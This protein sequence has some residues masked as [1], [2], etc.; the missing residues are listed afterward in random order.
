MKK[1]KKYFYNIITIMICLII[2][3]LPVS[4][5]TEEENIIDIK[6]IDS[7][8]S[9]KQSFGKVTPIMDTENDTSVVKKTSQ[10]TPLLA[11]GCYDGTPSGMCSSTKPRYCDESNTL[12]N[13]CSICGCSDNVRYRCES[14]GNCYYGNFKAELY[15]DYDEDREE[16]SLVYIDSRG[17]G[18]Y[19]YYGCSNCSWE[20]TGTYSKNPADYCDDG[21]IE[22][23]FNDRPSVD[24]GCNAM[25]KACFYNNY[26]WHCCQADCSS[27]GCN[28]K[29]KF[30]CTDFSCMPIGDC[31][32]GTP[33]GNC[34]TTGKYCN[35]YGVLVNDC[36]ECGCNY[37]S[38][39]EPDG[40]CQY[41]NIKIELSGDYN[42]ADEYSKLI[43]NNQYLYNR[44]TYPTCSSCSWD[45][46]PLLGRNLS[47][48]CVDNKLTIKLLD[49]PT[50]DEGCNAMHRAC[51]YDNYSWQ[52]CQADCSSYG[53]FSA[54]EFDCADFSCTTTTID[55]ITNYCY[56][57][58]LVG[59]CS[60]GKYCNESTGELTYDCSTCG[61]SDGY[62]CETN[63]R[64]NYGNFRIWLRGDYDGNS[65]EFSSVEIEGNSIDNFCESGCNQ[66][67]WSI[68]TL[69]QVPEDYCDDRFIE[70]SFSDEPTV[71]EGCNAMHK[72]CFYDNYSWHCCQ[73]DCSTYGCD[74]N[75]KF[76]CADFSCIT[77]TFCET[78]Q[79][80]YEGFWTNTIETYCS[81]ICCYRED[82]QQE[83]ILASGENRE[84]VTIERLSDD[85]IRVFYGE[86]VSL[87]IGRPYSADAEEIGD[88]YTVVINNGIEDISYGFRAEIDGCSISVTADIPISANTK[89]VSKYS[90]KEIFLVSDENWTN[91]LPF[92][93]VTTWTEGSTII[94]HPTLIYHDESSSFDADS[95]IYFMQ[96]YS[97]SSV[98]IIGPTPQ[99]LDNKL[100][101]SQLGGAG[102][103]EENIKRIDVD[104]HLFYWDSFDTLVYVEDDYELAILAS[105]YASLINAPL[106]IEGTS[107]D[108]EEFFSG[109]NVICVGSV[110]PTGGS[111]SEEYT[112][113]LLQQEY[114]TQTGTDKVILI[115]P[116]DWTAKVSS[117]LETEKSGYIYDL[118]SKTS[119]SAP[120]LASAKHELILSTTE[121]DYLNIDAFIEPQLSGMNYLT[122][123]A[124]FDL[125]PNEDFHATAGEYDY[126]WALDPSHYADITGDNEP[127]VAVGRIA[128]LST[129][130][131]SSYMARSIFYN[132]F[133][134]T[135]N[136]KFIASSFSGSLATMAER[137]SAIF[138]GAG[139]NSVAA[140]SPEENY[141]FD[142]IEWEN[143]DLIFYVDHGASSWAGISYNEIPFLENS[144]VLTA[145]C[146]TISDM[147][148]NSFWARAIR[149]GSIGF[150][151]GVSTTAVSTDYLDI[152]NKVYY[153]GNS[154]IGNATKETYDAAD[155][156]GMTTLIG[157]PTI[158]IN[159]NHLIR[160]EIPILELDLDAGMILDLL[161]DLGL[162][163]SPIIQTL[164]QCLPMESYC[165][166]Y[167]MCEM[168]GLLQCCGES[169]ACGRLAIAGKCCTKGD[170]DCFAGEFCG[171][172]KD[173][174]FDGEIDEE[175]CVCKN[176]NTH[177][178][179]NGNC[180]DCT[181]S[182]RY[183]CGTGSETN[184]LMVNEKYC[185]MNQCF[186]K[187]DIA[188][189]V[190]EDCGE[191]APADLSCNLLKT[192]VI[193]KYW[194]CD[195]FDDN[196]SK[197]LV[198]W[199]VE[200][201]D[202]GC[203]E[204]GG[205]HCMTNEEACFIN[206]SACFP[207]VTNCC[208]D[209]CKMLNCGY[210][211]EGD[212]CILGSDCGGDLPCKMLSCGLQQAGEGCILG[213][214]CGA[215]LPCKM[216]TC[217][218]QQAGDGCI[219]HSDCASGLR[220]D[221]FTCTSCKSDGSGCLLGAECCSS[222]QGCR[223]FSCGCQPDGSGCLSSDDCC[224]GS[225]CS[226]W[227]CKS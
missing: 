182:E 177:C 116:D 60:G 22:V 121:T 135:N 151:G 201:C 138:L 33:I 190:A 179:K 207:G 93:P 30:N 46:T 74:N 56:D 51:V 63:G 127:D 92:I 78:E 132:S 169:A 6:E 11:G 95:I 198:K 104:E 8:I 147:G 192:K 186:E 221:W 105:T 64:C 86:M 149:K 31:S 118:Y 153:H 34:S 52:C 24:E 180:E 203:S 136:M 175:D 137:M 18:A 204:D 185:N 28:N 44:C 187:A 73:A 69:G 71:D 88:K 49:E 38:R 193:G 223:M 112:L 36:S 224:S 45:T 184:K 120:I 81:G 5:Y 213:S 208:S 4:A 217:G 85:T 219:A 165:C 94:K 66:C 59:E 215:S 211:Q 2:I 19:C 26:S 77:E 82:V 13:N 174:D 158:D 16:Y 17:A 53:C 164:S 119:L 58:T 25:H 107:W 65:D 76:D 75:V 214:D 47:E 9:L 106:I 7:Q 90:S 72:A 205:A 61:C 70:V 79:D 102:L 131:V 62:R 154:I 196:C 39:C 122:I 126:S 43:I 199:D 170:P 35:D 14:N 144:L 89:S 178:G 108:L 200:D 15:G 84:N 109:R 130:D 189:D 188:A 195:L 172:E 167:E 145:S 176:S 96:Q 12:I 124:D 98:T 29:V 42:D 150:L 113:E 67:L 152:L 110:S 209:T 54:F 68:D 166:P 206:D 197:R 101:E 37:Y 143:Q 10:K 155:T 146:N 20:T 129:S 80:C 117:S 57:G 173:N 111:C 21:I 123:I 99:E 142:P 50:V 141:H 32:D 212:G 159:P 27:Y 227:E 171:D 134:K 163:Y 216:F 222:L 83:A 181:Q 148:L 218:K 194:K 140:T 1:Q 87:E 168:Y 220:C 41:G 183:F 133:T 91:V 226:W 157:D 100:I 23:T 225:T 114:K 48:Y 156:T 115:N 202:Y 103:L 97:P 161:E 40:L 139:Y 191:K 160:E 210:Q 125:I 162:D 55:T 128:G 3:L